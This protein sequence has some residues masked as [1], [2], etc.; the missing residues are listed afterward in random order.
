[1]NSLNIELDYK[2]DNTSLPYVKGVWT[3]KLCS[4]VNGS[5]NYSKQIGKYLRI[6]DMVYIYASISLS[7]KDTSASGFTYVSGLPFKPNPA[8]I[9]IP[10]SF[11][12]VNL[13]YPTGEFPVAY[14]HETNPNIFLMKGINNSNMTNIYM[15][16]IADNTSFM[17]SGCY[18][19]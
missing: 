11:N 2:W 12:Y 16:D 9:S 3:P 14:I 10:L 8:N 15:T 13:K 17:I 1:M 18:I 4:N 5:H 6:G 7:L 19:V